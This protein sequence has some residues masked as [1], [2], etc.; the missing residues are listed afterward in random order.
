MYLDQED[1]ERIIQYLSDAKKDLKALKTVKDLKRIKNKLIK[2]YDKS[3]HS[4]IEVQYYGAVKLAISEDVSRNTGL[5]SDGI[6]FILDSM[7][8]DKFKRYMK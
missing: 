4:D 7:G 3:F 2:K 1:K 5:S 6:M 8:L